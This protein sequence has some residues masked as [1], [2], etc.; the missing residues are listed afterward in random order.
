ML[1]AILWLKSL[2]KILAFGYYTIAFNE[3]YSIIA[4]SLTRERFLHFYCY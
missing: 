4:E 1:K 3:G 2:R